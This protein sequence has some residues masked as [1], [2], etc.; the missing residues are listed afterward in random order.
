M[1]LHR[2]SDPSR[3]D[4]P[5]PA[6]PGAERDRHGRFAPGNTTSRRGGNPNVR[7][8][9]DVQS[10]IRDAFSAAEV[11]AVL[12]ALH[13][14][15]IAG[16]VAAAATFVGRVCG[17]ARQLVQIDVPP[18]TDAASFGDAVRAIVSQVAAGEL[19]VAAGERVLALVTAAGDALVVEELDR[20]VAALEGRR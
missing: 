2:E 12:R 19:D 6:A 18:I 17:P 15:A 16:D 11:V 8:L 20:R 4:A 5:L 13:S 1:T 7:A 14:R 9:A 10:A 3:A